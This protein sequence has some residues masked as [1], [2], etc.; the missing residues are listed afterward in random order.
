LEEAVRMTLTDATEVLLGL[1]PSH[2][3]LEVE[4]QEEIYRICCSGHWKP[5]SE[6]HRHAYITWNIKN[7]PILHMGTDKLILRCVYSKPLIFRFPERS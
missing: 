5:K 1:P 7:E 3:K 4:A 2:L 6:R